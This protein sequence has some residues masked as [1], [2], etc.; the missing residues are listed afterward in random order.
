[1]GEEEEVRNIYEGRRRFNPKSNS[2]GFPNNSLKFSKFPNCKK[3]LVFRGFKSQEFPFSLIFYPSFYL[4]LSAI[5][6]C[7][8]PPFAVILKC[9]WRATLLRSLSHE[10][11]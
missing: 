3:T 8:Q 9:F 7:E 5:V 4:Q 1:M 10:N 2:S 6:R 11:F